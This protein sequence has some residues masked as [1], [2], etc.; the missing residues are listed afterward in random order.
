MF[1]WSRPGQGKWPRFLTAASAISISLFGC[2]TL[3]DSLAYEEFN[4]GAL[5][6]PWVNYQVTWPILI[7]GLVF[8]VCL[9]GTYFLVNSRRIVDFLLDTESEVKKVAWPG[10]NEVLGS[11]IVVIFTVLILSLYIAGVDMVFDW[12]MGQFVYG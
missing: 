10:W 4:V 11:S 8:L 12:F 1:A 7:S 9:A 2:L 3:H 6:I 5:T